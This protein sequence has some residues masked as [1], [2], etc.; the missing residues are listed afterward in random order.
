VPEARLLL[1]GA[2]NRPSDEEHIRSE[3]R[4]LKVL[5]RLEITGFRPRDEA[6]RL[7]S[8]ATVC[9]SPFFPTPILNSTSPTKLIEYMALERAVVAN[10]HPEQRLVLEQSRAGLCVPYDE[11]A[12]AAAIVYLLNHPEEAELMGERGRNYV[13]SHRDY[14]RIADA[15]ATEYRKIV[16]QATQ[17]KSTTIV[18]SR[19]EISG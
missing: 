4:R 15:V 9:V 1:V 7:I 6:L 2:G 8:R 16:Q 10:D 17:R 18:R 5:D 14:R 11:S 12:F 13:E 3:A 19:G